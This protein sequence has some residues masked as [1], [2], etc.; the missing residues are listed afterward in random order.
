MWKKT[1]W[2]QLYTPPGPYQL[3][4]VPPHPQQ[5]GHTQDTCWGRP[6]PAHRNLFSQLLGSMTFPAL[7]VSLLG[8]RDLNLGSQFQPEQLSLGVHPR[9]ALTLAPSL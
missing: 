4:G 7:R 2:G 5:A 9:Q 8:P 6:P 1:S 3:E